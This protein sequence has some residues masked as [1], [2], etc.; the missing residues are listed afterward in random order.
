MASKAFLKS[1]SK[2]AFDVLRKPAL[3]TRPQLAAPIA[4][5]TINQKSQQL[6]HPAFSLIDFLGVSQKLYVGEQGVLRSYGSTLA[7]ALFAAKRGGGKVDSDEDYEEDEDY[8]DVDA[9]DFDDDG[10]D[11]EFD[12]DDDDG[13]DEDESEKGKKSRRK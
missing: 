11:D 7:G 12:E 8:E 5:S 9:E 10:F 2:L 13:A 3:F 1:D 6:S 4:L